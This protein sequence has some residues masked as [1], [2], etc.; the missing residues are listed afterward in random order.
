M[1]LAGLIRDIIHN[2]PPLTHL[3]LSYFSYESEG[4]ESAGE[5]ILEALLNSSICTIQY[6]NLGHNSSWFKIINTDRRDRKGDREGA[7][8]MLT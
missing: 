8:E 4:R 7:I 2:N 3:D 6:L 5:I 1:I